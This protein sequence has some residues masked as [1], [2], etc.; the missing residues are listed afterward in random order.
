[1]NHSPILNKNSENTVPSII[2]SDVRIEGS[3]STIG[4]IQLEGVINGDLTCGKLIMGEHGAVKGLIISDNVVIRGKVEGSIRARTVRLEKTSKIKGDVY[5]E[6]LSVEAGSY[7][8][9]KFVHS[10]N[11]TNKNSSKPQEKVVS[12]KSIIS[13]ADNENL[14]NKAAV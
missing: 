11:P 8:N 1:M 13:G 4:E 12:S 5:H 6:S 7:I 10:N 14:S 9:G 2:A 3:I